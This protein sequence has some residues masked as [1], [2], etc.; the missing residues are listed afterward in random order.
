MKIK[1][2]LILL[3]F[4]AVANIACAQNFRVGDK[5][6]NIILSSPEGKEISLTDLEGK[7]VLIDFW[8]SWCGP[9]RMENPAVVRSWNEYKDKTFKAG[10]GYEVFSVSL[11]NNGDRWKQAIKQDNLMWQN[12][13]S[14]LKGWQSAA[15]QVYGVNSIPTNFLID[16]KGVILAVGLRG[17]ALQTTLKSLVKGQ[18]A[19]TTETFGLEKKSW[20]K[21]LFAKKD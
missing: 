12:H 13:V 3:A 21:R 14:D 19:E 8:A 16:G 15:A 20:W 10:K 11:D 17:E 5:A 18:A 2:N 7:I 6:P 9:C 1:N 4:L